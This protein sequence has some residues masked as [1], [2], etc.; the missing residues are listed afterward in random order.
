[1]DGVRL[2]AACVGAHV[3][4]EAGKGLDHNA[5]DSA[6]NWSAESHEQIHYWRAKSHYSAFLRRLDKL[7]SE[8]PEMRIFLATDLPE[9]Y[10]AFQQC[11]GERLHYLQRNVYDRSREQLVYALAD[12]LLLSRCS[13]LL[14]STW[15]SF[16]ELAM[17]ISTTLSAVEMSGKDF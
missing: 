2:P 4:M 3:R 5:Y 6:Q 9:N 12:A 1:V 8:Q 7:V 17:R 15:S 10:A 16:S 13:R 11:Y 14:G